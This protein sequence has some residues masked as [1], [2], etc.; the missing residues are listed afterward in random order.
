MLVID[1]ITAQ[2]QHGDINHCE[3]AQ[4]QQGGRAAKRRDLA[5]EG[6]Q[7]KGQERVNAIETYGVRRV[8]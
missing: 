2:N 3:H 5:D 6:D 4:Q 1:A 8:A 7:G